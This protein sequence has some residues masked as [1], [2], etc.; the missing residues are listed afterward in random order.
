MPGMPMMRAIVV[1]ALGI[2]TRAIVCKIV[3]KMM[4][5]KMTLMAILT[6]A[7]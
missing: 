1:T 7:W 3:G 5:M 4:A 6:K 2:M